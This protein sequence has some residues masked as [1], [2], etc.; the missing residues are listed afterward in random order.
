[1]PR[2]DNRAEITRFHFILPAVPGILRLQRVQLFRQGDQIDRGE[3]MNWERVARSS[4][5]AI[6]FVL[7]PL[8]GLMPA[9]GNTADYRTVADGSYSQIDLAGTTVTGSALV[10]CATFS[11]F[12]GL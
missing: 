9:G 3:I 5:C 11:G 2:F 10:V 7:F 1:A 6:G 12:R 8:F 4:L